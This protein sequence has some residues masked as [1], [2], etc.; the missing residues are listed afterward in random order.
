MCAWEDLEQN[1]WDDAVKSNGYLK[2]A[3]PSMLP[4]HPKPR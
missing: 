2:K 3:K 1:I 4:V